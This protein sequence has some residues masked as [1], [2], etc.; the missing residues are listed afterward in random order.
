MKDK[1]FL[2]LSIIIDF[3]RGGFCLATGAVFI[4]LLLG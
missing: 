2:S 4:M 3:K 1:T